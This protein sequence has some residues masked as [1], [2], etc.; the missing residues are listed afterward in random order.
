MKRVIVRLGNGLGNQLFTY[1]A[2]YSF[3]K[4]NN[5][6]LYVDDESGFYKRYKYE[7]HNFNIIAPIVEKKYKFVGH[8][9]RIKRRLLKKLSGINKNNIFLVE[10]VDEDKLTFYNPKQLNINFNNTL[11]FEGGFQSEKYFKSEKKNILKEFSFKDNVTNQA[12]SFIN[13]IKNN[14]SVSIHLRQGKFLKDEKYRDFEKKNLEY[15]NISMENINKGVDYF[16]KNIDNPTYFV[17]SN[18]FNGLKEFFPSKKFLLVEGNEKKDPA[19]DLYL[20][21]LCKH[22]ILSPSTMHYWAAYLSLND[23]KICLAPKDIKNKAGYYNFSNNIDI[24]AD[25]WKKI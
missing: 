11:Y 6:E 7:L 22:Y 10:E 8:V 19:Y 4:K 9:G 14:N 3:A 24:A 12:N 16:D 21:S 2:A 20:M 15:F 5:A 23:N 17:W 18:N 1:A 25:W 13:K